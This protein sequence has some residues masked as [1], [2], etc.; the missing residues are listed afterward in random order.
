MGTVS[1]YHI[2]RRFGGFFQKNT[3][4]RTEPPRVFSKI[5][6]PQKKIEK[7]SENI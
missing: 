2:R 3:V 1:L 6:I 5:E 7:N 4:L